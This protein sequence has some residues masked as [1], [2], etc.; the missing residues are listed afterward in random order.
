MLLERAHEGVLV[1]RSL[2]A[3]VTKLGAGVDELQLDILKSATLG[4]NEQRLKKTNI[5][6]NK[7]SVSEQGSKSWQ[8]QVNT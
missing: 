2:E 8:K 3:T 7:T 6:A 4:V 1:L 5:K